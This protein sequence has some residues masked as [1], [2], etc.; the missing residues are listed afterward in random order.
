MATPSSPLR[1]FPYSMSELVELSP[2][3]FATGDDHRVFVGRKATAEVV[4]ELETGE[5]RFGGPD[6]CP[7]GPFPDLGERDEREPPPKR[8]EVG[9]TLE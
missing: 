4:V 8:R 6:T 2:F 9:G 7:W 3:S 1:R 5:V